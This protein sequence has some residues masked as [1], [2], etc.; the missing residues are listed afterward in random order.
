M[1]A[2][3]LALA[4]AAGSAW[5]EEPP[6]L[7][8]RLVSAKAG[9]LE[10]TVVWISGGEKLPPVPFEPRARAMAQL[11]KRFSPTA[12]AIR[13]GE[14]VDFENLDSVFH[15]VFSLDKDN[16]FDLGL[17]KG[18]RHF[19]ADLKTEIPGATTVQ[20]FSK[21]GRF[22]VFCNIHPDMSATVFAFSHGY[23]AQA[24]ADGLF[25][26]PVPGPGRYTFVADGPMLESLAKSEIEV[27]DLSALL[28]L[29]VKARAS[30]RRVEHTRKDGSD[31]DGGY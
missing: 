18:K 23:F 9:R 8:G 10:G 16:P 31:Y 15:N 17:F 11:D 1:T 22:H 26:L 4:L 24:D 27:S 3:A 25:R 7:R 5:A 12:L 20:P 21:P 28:R 19:A 13:A 6:S 29:P 2:A 30:A 14:K